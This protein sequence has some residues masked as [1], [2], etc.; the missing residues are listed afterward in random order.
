MGGRSPQAFGTSSRIIHVDVHASAGGLRSIFHH[1]SDGDMQV[2]FSTS[3]SWVHSRLMPTA[4]SFAH[5]VAD[6]VDMDAS[7]T[8]HMTASEQ[9]LVRRLHFEQG[10]TRSD[11]SRLLE[12][13][14]SSISRLLAQKKAPRRSGRPRK[15]TE[16]NIDRIVATLEKMVDTVDGDDEITLHMLMRRCLVKASYLSHYCEHT[17]DNYITII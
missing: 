12:R 9:A 7:K 1:L 5:I 13:S 3:M 11:I 2:R 15:L 4:C 8:P 6:L 17:R 10:K 14:L 16:A